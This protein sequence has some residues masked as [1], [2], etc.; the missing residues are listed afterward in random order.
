MGDVVEMRL[1]RNE[2]EG[3]SLFHMLQNKAHFLVLVQ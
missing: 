3:A 2:Y 1:K